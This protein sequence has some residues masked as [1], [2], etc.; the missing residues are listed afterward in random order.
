M[1]CEASF[2]IL[3]SYQSDNTG[4]KYFTALKGLKVKRVLFNGHC[5][6]FSLLAKCIIKPL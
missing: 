6:S 1:T 4:V 3:D 2:I 5:Q